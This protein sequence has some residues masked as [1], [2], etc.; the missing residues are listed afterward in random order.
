MTPTPRAHPAPTA[1]LLAIAAV[2]LA[3][4]MLASATGLV[5]TLRPPIPQLILITLTVLLIAAGVFLP[6]FRAWLVS[7]DLRAVVA[8]HLTRL[9]AGAAFLVFHARGQLSGA[10]AIPAGW[11]DIVVAVFAVA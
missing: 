8:L 4:A 10:F 11:G 1:I 3:V 9:A 2:W 5:A 6:R 7:V